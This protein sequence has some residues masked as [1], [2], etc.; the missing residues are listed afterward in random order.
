MNKVVLQPTGSR[1]AQEHYKNTI[2]TPVRDAVFHEYLSSSSY[3]ELQATYHGASVPTWGVVPG[4]NNGNQ[5]R[6]ERIEPGDFALFCSAGAV[7]SYGEITVKFRNAQLARRLW[8]PTSET[9]HGNT[10]TACARS[11]R[12]TRPTGF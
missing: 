2:V 5:K 6:W 10:F 3:G 1:T 9:T 8:V 11:S 7:F 4:E 12:F